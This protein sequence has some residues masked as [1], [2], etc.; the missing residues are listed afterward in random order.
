MFLHQRAV[1]LFTVGALVASCATTMADR[2]RKKMM[3]ALT[4]ID[5]AAGVERISQRA[6][7]PWMITQAL[8]YS[9]VKVNYAQFCAISGWSAELRYDAGRKAPVGMSFDRLPAGRCFV[10]GVGYCGR[11]LEIFS[12]P[13]VETENDRLLAARAAW[14]FVVSSLASDRPVVTDYLDGGVFYGYD[15]S[16]DDP[17]IYFSTNG[18]GFGALRRSQFGEAYRRGLQSLAVIADDEDGPDSRV[19][20]VACLSNLA[21]KSAEATSDGAPAGIAAMQALGADLLDPARKWAPDADWLVRPL[22]TQAQTRLCTAVYL[23]QNA[24]LLGEAVKP[25]LVAAADAYDRAFDAWRL[26]LEATTLTGGKSDARPTAER[27]ADP[28]RREA[29]AGCVYQALGAELTALGE[30]NQAIAILKGP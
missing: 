29:I 15:E 25:H 26:C 20:L 12:W 28:G 14:E 13:E 4:A 10:R 19:L 21:L 2:P 3:E 9:G 6:S 7:L 18:P 8:V 5:V 16:L 24:G 22:G 30:I 27:L 1:L 11:R 23:R 17:V